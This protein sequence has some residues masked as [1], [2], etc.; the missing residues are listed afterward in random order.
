MICPD[1]ETL[2]LAIAL[3]EKLR[4][5]HGTDEDQQDLVALLDCFIQDERTRH[6]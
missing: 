5:L 1:Q 6:S 2:E 4:Y 3:H